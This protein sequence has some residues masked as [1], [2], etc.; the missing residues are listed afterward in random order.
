MNN[1]F[2]LIHDNFLVH[3]AAELTREVVARTVSSV[4]WDATRSTVKKFIS[5]LLGT[6]VDVI[7]E[8]L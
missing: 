4:A 1:L 6:C 7:E 2:V 3:I 8:C 5:N